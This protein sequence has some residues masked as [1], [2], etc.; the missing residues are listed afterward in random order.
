[1]AMGQKGGIRSDF[2]MVNFPGGTSW[3]YGKHPAGASEEIKA[4]DKAK[5]GSN[6]LPYAK[7]KKAVALFFN[8]PIATMEDMLKASTRTKNLTYNAITHKSTSLANVGATG[9]GRV[10]R[11][12]FKKV[13]TIGKKKVA[14]INIPMPPSYTM[15]NMIKYLMSST[16]GA[17]IASVISPA[18]KSWVFDSKYKPASMAK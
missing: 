7:V 14:S 4:M 16:K 10:V 5:G 13:Q 18:G 9:K 8:M 3:R 2:V 11:V 12:N 17:T 1:M 6:K 15:G